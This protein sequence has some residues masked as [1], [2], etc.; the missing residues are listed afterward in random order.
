MGAGPRICG[1]NT[2]TGKTGAPLYRLWLQMKTSRHAPAALH[3]FWA[4]SAHC[5]IFSHALARD[6]TNSVL[7]AGKYCD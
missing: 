1:A 2:S 3:K 5:P 6:R 7:E 4:D